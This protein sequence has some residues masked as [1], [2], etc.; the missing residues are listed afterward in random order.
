MT[1]TADDPLAA[2]CRRVVAWALSYTTTPRVQLV[3][4]PDDRP[5]VEAYEQ[6]L[7]LYPGAFSRLLD[8]ESLSYSIVAQPG[9]PVAYLPAWG[10]YLRIGERP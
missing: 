7:Q 9:E 3:L 4:H 10:R 6:R 2:A 1:G 8:A 5:L